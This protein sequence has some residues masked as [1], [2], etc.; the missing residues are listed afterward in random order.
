[1][2]EDGVDIVIQESDLTPDLTVQQDV[3]I[4]DEPVFRQNGVE[5]KLAR[6]LDPTNPD[7]IHIPETPHLFTVD[8]LF[9]RDGKYAAAALAADTSLQVDP[10][11]IGEINLGKS[12]I[13]MAHGQVSNG[14]WEF[15]NGQEIAKTVTT[16][17]DYAIQH[18]LP[19]ID[20]I[21]ACNPPTPTSSAAPHGMQVSELGDHDRS[22]TVAYAV[23]ENIVAFGESGTE[24]TELHVLAQGPMMHLDRLITYKS[25]FPES[26]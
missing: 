22:G 12:T 3:S 15:A 21:V 24:G 26:R 8:R 10:R 13:I 4:A 6:P 23:G 7:L 25:I 2:A 16:Y 19:P 14:K 5:I 18:R 9:V 11:Y 17:N 20:L 1:M